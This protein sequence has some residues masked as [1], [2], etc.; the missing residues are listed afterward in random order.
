MQNEVYEANT[1]MASTVKLT[2]DKSSAPDIH[3]DFSPEVTTEAKSEDLTDSFEKSS[4][5]PFFSISAHSS[6]SFSVTT[7]PSHLSGV[8]D[9]STIDS[10]V[11]ISAP[12]SVKTATPHSEGYPDFEDENEPSESGPSIRQS[13]LLDEKFS[14]DNKIIPEMSESTF[15]SAAASSQSASDSVAFSQTEENT[16]AAS[17]NASNSKQ[18]IESQTISSISS[19]TKEPKIQESTAEN[20]SD[21]SRKTSL[22]NLDLD[23]EMQTSSPLMGEEDQIVSTIES[24]RSQE[25]VTASSTAENEKYSS[26]SEAQDN[27]TMQKEV[28]SSIEIGTTAHIRETTQL[29]QISS[30]AND[31]ASAEPSTN[32]GSTT[33][34]KTSSDNS[35]AI[36]KSSI[37]LGSSISQSSAAGVSENNTTGKH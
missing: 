16:N 3:P 9:S 29:E 35:Y 36:S 18:V 12:I 17:T 24:Y 33:Q 19:I 13:T 31:L 1:K 20:T 8:G 26:S 28:I 14:R 23:Q 10:E 6:S 2:S 11:Q 4:S 21:L 32:S 7:D 37:P 25:S 5:S 22:E 15:S 34:S 30:I 27:P